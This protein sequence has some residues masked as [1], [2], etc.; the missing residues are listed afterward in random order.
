MKTIFPTLF[1]EMCGI[2]RDISRDEQSTF[3]M[4]SNA[5]G[6]EHWSVLSEHGGALTV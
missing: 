3:V 4:N 1:P 5:S 6:S 2:V